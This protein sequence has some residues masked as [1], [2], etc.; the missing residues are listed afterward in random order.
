MRASLAAALALALVSSGPAEARPA[1]LTVDQMRAFGM[2]ALAKG[3]ADQAL[4]IADT[5]LARDPSDSAALSLKA[6]ALRILGRLPES[7]AAARAAWASARDPAARYAAASAVAQ[8]LSLQ[9]H[10]TK[11]QFWLRQAVQNAP[12]AATR[13]QAVEDFNYVRAQ[14][15]LGL[16]FQTSLRPSANVTNGTRDPSFTILG[17]TFPFLPEQQA[18]AG[19]AGA[20]GISGDYRLAETDRGITKLTFS[21][22]TQQIWLSPNARKK[23]PAARNSDYAYNALEIGLSHRAALGNAGDVGHVDLTF[24]HDWYGGADLSNYATLELGVEHP[25]SDRTTGEAAIVLQRQLRLDRPQ[26][27]TGTVSVTLGG[28][29]KLAGGDLLRLS[30]D[31]GHAQ[32]QGTTYYTSSGVN[33]DWQKAAP[34]AGMDL[35]ASLGLARRDYPRWFLYPEG[36]HD[37]I[38]TASVQATVGA[39]SYLGFSP[40]ISVSFNRNASNT[41]LNDTQNLGIGLSVQSRF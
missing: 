35:A 1:V 27:S 34:V 39:I 29:Q 2:E 21:G 9:D 5:L 4:S 28:T 20:F 38:L 16:T 18:L 25:L 13:Q 14:N 6:Q 12:N 41:E 3:Y 30:F 26:A 11:A 23:A 31:L 10:R 15:P 40:V 7:E 8:A 19:V 22:S 32:Q 33:L 36:R 24:G 37:V 17:L